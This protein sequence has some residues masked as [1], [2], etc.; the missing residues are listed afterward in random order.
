MGGKQFKKETGTCK[1][2]EARTRLVPGSGGSSVWGNTTRGGEVEADE[3]REGDW[4]HPVLKFVA[5]SLDF[6]RWFGQYLIKS[7]N[8]NTEY[9]LTI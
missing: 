6:I 7:C 8:Y 5:R 2:P 3:V 1:D 4:G 9:V